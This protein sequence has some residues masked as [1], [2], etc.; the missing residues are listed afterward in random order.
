MENSCEVNKRPGT[1]REFIRSSYFLRPFLGVVLGGVAGFLYYF[2]VG[3][4]SGSC[5][6]TNDPY[7]SIIAGSF[8][9][10]FILNSPCS[11]C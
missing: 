8:L 3:C 5:A 10:F 2:F 9:G 11:K 6:I 1:F 4:V 7:M